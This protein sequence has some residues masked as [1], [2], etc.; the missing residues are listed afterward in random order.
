MAEVD[1]SP[2][3]LIHIP[4]L[5]RS[6][7]GMTI[8]Q[9]SDLHV[10]PYI[11]HKELDY[12]VG[13]ANQL[14]PDLVVLTGDIIDRSLASLPDAI[15]G[16]AGLRPELGTVAV[17]GNHDISSDRF[18]SRPEFLGGERIAEAIQRIGVRTL[19][20]EV[21][22]LALGQDRLAIMGLDWITSGSG[23]VG[24]P[25]V[26]NFFR[27]HP[28][29]TIPE[30]SRMITQVSQETST[31]LLA[32]HPDTFG[33]VGPFGIGLTLYGHT[34]GGGQ[35]VFM[36]WDGK[37]VGISSARFKYVSGL[38]R[39][40]GR[41]LYVNRGLGYLGVPIRINCPPEISRFRLTRAQST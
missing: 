33:D 41:S 7:E 10:G 22:H 24:A 35:I 12:W 36:R 37:P 40:N 26:R 2:E 19:R 14:R 1:I 11:R 31:I 5:P 8:V 38:Y 18:S 21:T 28:A 25:R 16:L 23:D 27:Y 20:N 34:H 17:L 9:L 39:E 15:N 29:E 30:L 3:I 4:H 32:H 6:F 13:L